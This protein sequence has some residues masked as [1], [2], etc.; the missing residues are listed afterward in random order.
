[1]SS[2]IFRAFSSTPLIAGPHCRRHLK[3]ARTWPTLLLAVLLAWE[4]CGIR[5][6]VAR[7]SRSSGDIPQLD[8]FSEPAVAI[9]ILQQHV[10]N[11]YF[12]PARD[13]NGTNEVLRPREAASNFSAWVSPGN[14][15]FAAPPFFSSGSQ[16]SEPDPNRQSLSEL[17]GRLSA[18][19]AQL[20][21]NLLALHYQNHSWNDFLDCYLQ[22]LV[23]QPE[24]VVCSWTR[25]ALACSPICGR[26]DEILDALQHFT[27]FSKDTN[28]VARLQVVLEDWNAGKI[29]EFADNASGPET[30]WLCLAANHSAVPT[31]AGH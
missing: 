20:L 10:Q 1:M 24:Q 9:A 31:R 13:F 3:I 2:R 21:Q 30:G 22:L 12:A 27:R 8:S 19:Q 18:L 4:L 23:A 29:H 26:T 17:H 7:V 28:A 11:L 15:N 25:S 16:K 6:G 14:Q 5:F